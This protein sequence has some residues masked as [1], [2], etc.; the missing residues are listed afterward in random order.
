M[1][2]LSLCAK[3]H[4]HSNV[5]LRKFKVGVLVIVFVVVVNFKSKVNS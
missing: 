3:F 1:Y 4:S 5:L 2:E